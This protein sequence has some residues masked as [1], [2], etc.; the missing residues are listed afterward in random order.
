MSRPRTP[1]RLRCLE[2]NPGGGR[3]RLAPRL[4]RAAARSRPVGA[5]RLPA[6]GLERRRALPPRG[7]A[8]APSAGGGP[9][10]WAGSGRCVRPGSILPGPRAPPPLGRRRGPG[11]PAPPRPRVPLAVLWLRGFVRPGLC[12][13]APQALGSEGWVLRRPRKAFLLAAAGTQARRV[14]EPPRLPPPPTK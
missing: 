7:W 4:P 14:G 8:D 13:A 10:R 6:P 1:N 11:A 12:L 3:A 2:G 5:P 9:G